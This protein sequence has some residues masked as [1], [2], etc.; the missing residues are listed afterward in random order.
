MGVLDDLAE[1]VD[2]TAEIAS[3]AA[4][5]GQKVLEV[6]NQLTTARGIVV[7]VDN[8]LTDITLTRIR[9]RDNFSSG[10]LGPVLPADEIPPHKADIFAVA[11]KGGAVGTGVVGSVTYSVAGFT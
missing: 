6:K 2:T 8:H 4:A 1:G 11:S 9:A 7:E 3:S 5:A 10:G